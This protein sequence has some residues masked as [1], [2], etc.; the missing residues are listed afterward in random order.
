MRTQRAAMSEDKYQHILQGNRN[1]HLAAYVPANSGCT[2]NNTQ[3]PP[4]P[5]NELKHQ[6]FRDWQNKMNPESW[7]M[8]ACAVCAHRIPQKDIHVVLP[9]EVDFSLLQNPHLPDYTRPTTYNSGAYQN[10]ILYPK[11]MHDKMK[12]ASLDMCKK[13]E[14]ALVVQRKQPTGTIQG[15]TSYLLMYMKPLQLPPCLM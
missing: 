7:K 10:A 1:E 12:L 14:Q 4:V 3:F 15:L 5:N 8:T 6:I 9:K 11:G 13:C 2:T